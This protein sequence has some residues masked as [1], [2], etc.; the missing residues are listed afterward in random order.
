MFKEIKF[1]LF[2]IKKNLQN[3]A[4]LRTSFLLSIFGMAINNL[5][6]IFLWVFFVKSVGVVGGWTASDVVGLQGFVAISYGLIS[7]V[8]MGLRKLP[9]YVS[10]GSFDRFLL[11]P[12]NLLVRVAT[13]ALNTAALGDV[14]FGIICLVTYS[15]LISASVY[16]IIMIILLALLATMVFLGVVIAIA[17]VSFYFTD[18]G[19]VAMGF[20]EL[21]LTPA[22]FHG[23]AFQGL[24]RFVYTFIV[25]SLLLG[26]LPVEA[27]RSLSITKLALIAILAFL[28]LFISIK[29]FK[30]AVKKYESTNFMT[31]GS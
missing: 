6:F 22:L 12:K 24:L 26:T 14:L 9:E 4:E 29:F 16:Q 13:A 15:F 31:Y 18:S 21:F 3:S 28:W 20:F 7:S 17:A 5:A 30:R 8:A 11:S 23:G 19:V 25:P 10:A 2:A 27:V 1:A